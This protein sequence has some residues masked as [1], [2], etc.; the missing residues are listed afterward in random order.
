MKSISL[1][2]LGE[3]IR[4]ALASRRL[5]GA[6]SGDGFCLLVVASYF[7]RSSEMDFSSFCLYFNLMAGINEMSSWSFARNVD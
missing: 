6:G 4:P 2:F 3:D 1:H 7:W 5:P